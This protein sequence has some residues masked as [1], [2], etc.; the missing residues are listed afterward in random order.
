MQQGGVVVLKKNAGS[1]CGVPF[2]VDRCRGWKDD[3]DVVFIQMRLV[4]GGGRSW[5]VEH[6]GSKSV[7][8]DMFLVN[9]LLFSV[10]FCSS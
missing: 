7:H 10:F 6:V 5:L 3:V 2:L 1:F 9:I 4:I 8:G